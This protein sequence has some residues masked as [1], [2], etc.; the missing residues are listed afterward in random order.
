MHRHTFYR[1]ARTYPP[2]LPADDI[3]ISAPPVVPQAPGGILT[4]L[5]YLLPSLGGVGALVF[6]FAFPANPLMIIAGATIGVSM[7]TTG[8][9]MGIVQRRTAKKQLQQQMSSYM[10]YLAH[11]RKRLAVIKHE[12]LQFNDRLYPSY[13][14]IERN[15][16]RRLFLWERQ[17]ADVDFMR[18]RIGLGPGPLCCEISLD[19]GQANFAVQFIPEMLAQ[20]KGLMAEFSYLSDLPALIEL[21]KTHVLTL[22]GPHERTRAMARALLCQLV[23]FHSPEDVRCLACFPL[24]QARDWKWLKWL[25]HTRRLRQV[26]AESPHAPEHISLLANTAEDLQRLLQQQIKPE[27]EHRQRLI[28]DQ[29]SNEELQKGA[30][31]TF[32]HL[33]ILLDGYAPRNSFGQVAELEAILNQH[34]MPGVTV[35]CLVDDRSQEPAQVTARLSISEAGGLTFEEVRYGGRHLEGLIADAGDAQLC[36]RIARNMAPLT[37]A[38]ASGK[39]D[40]S[41]DVRLLDLLN[42]SAADAFDPALTWRPRERT[43]LLRIPLGQK[44]DGHI[45]YLD[46]KEA[47]DRG[48]GPHGLIVGATGSGKS[49]LLRTIVSALSI[50]HDPRTLNFVLVDFK[51]G[52]SFADFAPLPHV[53]GIVTNLQSDLALVDRVYSA[54]LGEQQRRQRLL[55]EAGNLDNIKQYHTLWQTNPQMEPMPHLMIIVD[56]FAELIASRS[57][58]LELFVQ[59]GRVGR[60][61][62]LYLLFATQRLD[63]GRIKGLESYLR[64]R[65]CLRTYSAYESKTVLEKPD[66]YYLPSMPGMGYFKVDTDIY[67][68][69]KAALISAPHVPLAE[70]GLLE[71][72]VRIFSPAGKLVLHRLP[73]THTS[74]MRQEQGQ[75]EPRTEMSIVIERLAAAEHKVTDARVHQV[76]LPPLEK[77][78]PLGSVLE[79][80]SQTKLDGSSWDMLPAF[81]DLRVPVGLLDMPQQQE[82]EPLWL[83]FSGIGGHLALVGAPQS[84]KSMFL[85]TLVTALMLTHSPQN[86]QIY[87]IDL[88]GGL[89]RIFEQAPHVGAVCSKSERDKVRRVIRQ[90]RKVIE[91]REFLFRERGIDSMATFR[92]RRQRG[93]FAD[94][95]F[96]DVFLLI[97]NFGQFYQEFEQL[98]S[99]LIEL[100]ASGLNYGVHLILAANRWAEIRVKL[101]DN[102]GTRLELRLNDPIESELGRVTASALPI[103]A[104]GRGAN[105]DK[106]FF[107]VALPVLSNVTLAR[108]KLNNS[109]QQALTTLVQRTR[110]SWQGES[111][112]SIYI[113]PA[114]IRYEDLPSPQKS[115]GVPL[116]LEEFRLS[117]FYVNLISQGPHFMVLG[118]RECGKTS[119]L[120][121]WMRGIEQ[122]YT[123]QEAAFA[124]VDLRRRL[125]DFTE[126]KHL[127][128]YAYNSLTLTTC[129]GNLKTDLERRTQKSTDLPLSELRNAPAWSGRHFFLF[130]DDYETLLSASGNPLLP[131]AEYLF[132]ARDIGFHLVLVHSVGGFNRVS[133]EPIFQRLREM[134]S[135]GLI[136]SGDPSE[137]RLLHAV[138][139]T[140][141]PPGRAYFV[142]P[143]HPPTL[144]Q[145]ALARE[146]H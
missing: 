89:L 115:S 129:V 37:L 121:A 21:R 143:K 83:D 69:F 109:I 145:T 74:L 30:T 144:V 2:L 80:C 98:E 71:G 105:R 66:A 58:F 24:K 107:Q 124:I 126:S 43:D 44:A 90:A 38:E 47:A 108:D 4:W 139:A 132:S 96:G 138:A 81:G 35:I 64:Y 52:A 16:E 59:M 62:G 8:F 94:V 63:E 57:D 29:Q 106:L 141:L 101:R 100:V 86:V 34:E 112:P 68:L 79:R 49:E 118:D 93:D 51:G 103:D 31:Q 53:A 111:A 117:P 17:P 136:L 11:L 48:M 39:Q 12:Q 33:V 42:I 85:R 95:P 78:L 119:L 70:K 82:Q 1:P 87:C 26:K 54:L 23:A 120:R 41:Q 122:A 19:T 116:G 60:S 56:E 84:G 88:G 36:E 6:I 102:I 18:L 146:T 114:L 113:L 22:T 123:P 135:A 55:H 110:L 125:L 142:Q 72:R 9:V 92:A 32:P 46:L 25:P 14:D 131:L 104:P 75:G 76:W 3:V 15:V 10:E 61:L 50:T 140:S 91:E 99:E 134:G 97:D 27:L 65:I 67:E 45:L 130:V 7:I 127:L 13:E 137:G 5:Q 28:Q 128:A 20:A 73:S 77:V 40:F 133:Y